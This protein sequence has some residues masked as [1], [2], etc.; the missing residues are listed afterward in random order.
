MKRRIKLSKSDR[1]F[2]TKYG[3]DPGVPSGNTLT[4]EQ[5]GGLLLEQVKQMTP[6]EKAEVRACLEWSLLLTAADRRWLWEIG[7]SR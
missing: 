4:T 2:W 7:I 6:E 1:A 3:I 5:L